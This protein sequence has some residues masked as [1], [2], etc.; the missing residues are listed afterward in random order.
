[1]RED[2][3]ELI[4]RNPAFGACALWHVARAFADKHEG[5]S[6]TLPHMILSVAML[7]HAG[8]VEKIARMNF[9]SGLLKATVEEPELLAGLQRRVEA[10]LPACL[11]ALQVGVAAKILEREGGLGLPTFRALGT[12]LPVAIRETNQTN[13]SA[14][15]LGMWLAADDL[16]ALQSRLGVRF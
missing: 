2:H 14:K 1:V 13:A 8:T 5:K 9:D 6:P 16:A 3:E 4:A 10:A 7:F 11:R 12:A 15:R